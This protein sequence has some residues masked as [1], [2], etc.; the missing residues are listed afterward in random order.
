M[1]DKVHLRLKEHVWQSTDGMSKLNKAMED[2]LLEEPGKCLFR[3]RLVTSNDIF[4]SK[5]G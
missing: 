5:L 3:Q 2:S 1:Y 4:F